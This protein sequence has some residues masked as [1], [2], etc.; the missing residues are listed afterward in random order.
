MQFCKLLNNRPFS[1]M[2]CPR[3][4]DLNLFGDN[5]CLYS[6]NL[7]ADKNSEVS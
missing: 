3:Y 1:V 7:V 2:N 6:S 5:F 4:S